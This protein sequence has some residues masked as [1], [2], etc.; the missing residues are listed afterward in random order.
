MA[1]NWSR[2][3]VGAVVLGLAALSAAPTATAREAST[4][5]GVA[6]VVRTVCRVELNSTPTVV[7]PTEIDLGQ[8]TELCNDG[9]GYSVTLNTPPGLTGGTVVIA[10]EAPTPI[11][12]SGHTLIVD[13]N[14]KVVLRHRDL[15]LE[16][17][18]GSP[19]VIAVS[20]TAWPK[21]PIY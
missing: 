4:S 10:G 13:A 18:A 16:L 12:P 14:T 7:S 19:P 1:H 17:A 2:L 5:F 15:R 9:G 8:M 3:G 6:V 11:D 20:V 21:G